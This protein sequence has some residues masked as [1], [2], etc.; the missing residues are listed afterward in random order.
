MGGILYTQVICIFQCLYAGA[1]YLLNY[2]FFCLERVSLPDV[3]ILK[4]LLATIIIIIQNIRKGQ[5]LHGYSPK[6][7]LLS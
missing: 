5:I 2:T 3:Q 1:I 7:K 6:A 4:T